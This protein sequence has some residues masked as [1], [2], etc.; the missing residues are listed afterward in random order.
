MALKVIN[1]INSRL[2]FLYR[3]NRYLTPYLKRLL[4]NALIQ[5]RFDYACSAW[6]PNLNKKLKSKLHTDQKR[7]I[8]YRLQ[9]DIEVILEWNTLKKLTGSS[10]LNNLI[11]PFVLNLLNFLRK[12][13]L[14]APVPNNSPPCLL[15]FLLP[16]LIWTPAY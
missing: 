7:C 1:K 4:C 16:F 8:R 3:K 9:V 5:P 10:F 15:I 6:Y 14:H 12:L 11:G 2:K 13:V